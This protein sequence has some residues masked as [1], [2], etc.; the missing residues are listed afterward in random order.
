MPNPAEEIW[1]GIA[2][3][4]MKKASGPLFEEKAAAE[5]APK[6]PRAKIAADKRLSQRAGILCTEMRF[7]RF[8]EGDAGVSVSS[9]NE[10]AQVLRSMCG[11]GSRSEIVIGTE[12]GDRF[13]QL[14]GRYAGWLI[15]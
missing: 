9:E 1:C 14:L 12:E 15:E 7:W 13:E 10:A 5:P 4:D 3:L 6:A 8:L 11:V 2:R